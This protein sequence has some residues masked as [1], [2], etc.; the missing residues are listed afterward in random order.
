MAHRD[1]P[2]LQGILKNDDN[3]QAAQNDQPVSPSQL[4]NIRGAQ[5]PKEGPKCM[6]LFYLPPRLDAIFSMTCMSR[7]GL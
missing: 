3:A 7:I 4:L 6:C 1:S 5:S 2:K